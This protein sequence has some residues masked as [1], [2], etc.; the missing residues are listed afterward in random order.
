MAKPFICE[1]CGASG[2]DNS[3]RGNKRFCGP[4]C[5]NIAYRREHGIGQKRAD[6]P[7]CFFNEGV[8]CKD[9]WR[10]RCGWNPTVAKRRL[11]AACQMEV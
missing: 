1:V 5:S 8:E 11:V 3:T 10:Y 2:I 9:H 6:Y 7:Q 4:S